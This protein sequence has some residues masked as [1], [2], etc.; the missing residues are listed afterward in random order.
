[1]L[2]FIK[3]WYQG[4]EYNISTPTLPIF[5]GIRYK[6]H[7]SSRFAHILVEFYLKEWKWLLPF[8]LGL[9]TIFLGL[10][11]LILRIIKF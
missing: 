5:P 2:K 11:G 10:I 6:R 9:I 7:W 8:L 3:Q 1:M 4:E